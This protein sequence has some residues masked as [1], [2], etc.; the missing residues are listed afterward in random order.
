M[1]GRLL[2]KIILEKELKKNPG[3]LFAGLDRSEKGA[4]SRASTL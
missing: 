2:G 3:P 4:E 1:K